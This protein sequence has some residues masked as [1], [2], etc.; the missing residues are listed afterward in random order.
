MFTRAT[1]LSIL[2]LGLL[3]EASFAGV[4]G[5]VVDDGEINRTAVLASEMGTAD[6]ALPIE[7]EQRSS[8][9]GGLHVFPENASVSVSALADF[10]ES[11]TVVRDITGRLRVANCSLPAIPDPDEL[12]KPPQV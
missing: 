2:A 9:S 3:V 7:L 11:L 1:I 6:P 8:E 4:I 12:L 5:Q 10:S